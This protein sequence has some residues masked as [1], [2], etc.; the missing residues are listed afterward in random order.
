MPE[1]NNNADNARAG[2]RNRN[3]PDERNNNIGFRV[4]SSAHIPV[5]ADL[6][7]I[8]DHGLRYTKAAA[9]IRSSFR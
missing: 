3:H 2:Y 4:V 7:E 1:P 9:L 8:A 6:V 5:A